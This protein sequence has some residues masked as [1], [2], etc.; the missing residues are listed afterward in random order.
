MGGYGT[1]SME[2]DKELKKLG[3]S[4]GNTDMAF[5]RDMLIKIVYK[6]GNIP[7]VHWIYSA[8]IYTWILFLLAGYIII[9]KQYRRLIVLV[10]SF[11]IL[12][13]CMLSPVNNY[14]RYALPMMAATPIVIF[15]AIYKAEIE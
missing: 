3:I 11:T 7:I 8:G 1:F 13:T 12:L 10:P 15:N 6:L 9:N 14:M 2:L 4:Y 5:G